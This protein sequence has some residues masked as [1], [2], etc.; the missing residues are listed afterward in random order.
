MT[1]VTNISTRAKDFYQQLEESSNVHLV[2]CHCRG[3]T[4]SLSLGNYFNRYEAVWR[5]FDLAN[6]TRGIC[7]ASFD[8]IIRRIGTH[9]DWKENS[10]GQVGRR[11]DIRLGQIQ[12]RRSDAKR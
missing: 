12:S 9:R 11:M 3:P 4:R 6:V 10:D 5:R 8:D 1:T 7:H 2:R